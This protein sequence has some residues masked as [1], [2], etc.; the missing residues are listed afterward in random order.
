MLESL[1]AAALSSLLKSLPSLPK[2]EKA[3]LLD[4]IESLT[5]KKAI[6]AARDDFLQF[7]ARL[8]PDWK[9][10]PHHRFLKPILHEVQAGSQTRLTVSMPPR[11]GKSET[12]AY[13]FV[14]WYLGHNP[15][16]HIMM[17]THT[18]AL[19]ADFGRKVR[20]LIDSPTYQEL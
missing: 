8:Y 14:A 20:N 2:A 5:H 13:L 18:A 1:D 12:I 6:K 7:C 19:S 9:E 15:H 16:H 11:F 17:V 4:E 10:G 3:A